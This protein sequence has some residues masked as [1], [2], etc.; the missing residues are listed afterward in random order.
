[1]SAQRYFPNG[2]PDYETDWIHERNMGW[3]FFAIGIL[4]DLVLTIRGLTGF[5]K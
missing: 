5:S 2:N 4:D 3:G 1:M